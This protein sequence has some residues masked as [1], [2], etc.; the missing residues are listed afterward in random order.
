MT[1]PD[2]N[3]VFFATTQRD[4][5]AAERVLD[6]TGID[7]SVR[8]EVIEERRADGVC[9][10]GMLYEVPSA[11]APRCRELLIES[12]LQRGIIDENTRLR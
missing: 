11:E 4:E 5:A 8:L 7:Y 6:A 1:T 10:Q 2:L 12:G 3:P 9:Y